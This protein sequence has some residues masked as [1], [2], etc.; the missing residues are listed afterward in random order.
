MCP[1]K[2]FSNL[3]F[4]FRLT[5][6]CCSTACN[7]VC[8]VLYFSFFLVPSSLAGVV[9]EFYGFGLSGV[10]CF[11]FSSFVSFFS[12]C[13]SLFS[14]LSSPSSPLRRRSCAF[15]CHVLR[16]VPCRILLRP[17]RL[18]FCRPSPSVA[19]GVPLSWLFFA[20]GPREGC[21]QSSLADVPALQLEVLLQGSGRVG[22]SSFSFLLSCSASLLALRWFACSAFSRGSSPLFSR[23]D[24]HS[25]CELDFPFFSSS[26]K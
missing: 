26:R 5:C 3:C 7:H 23:R 14:L 21:G 12:S 22:R 25:H 16:T 18:A 19:C 8:M 2:G 24:L 1:S 9:L 10:S 4:C 13:A 6:K 20:P 11:F 17:A 15:L